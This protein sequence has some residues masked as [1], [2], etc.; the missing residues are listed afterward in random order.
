[1]EDEANH[2]YS[3]DTICHDYAPG[4]YLPMANRFDGFIICGNNGESV[5]KKCQSGLIYNA[6]T[7]TCENGNRSLLNIDVGKGI[8]GAFRTLYIRFNIM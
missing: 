2:Q 6:L 1:M 5:A 7:T 8:V 4:T 3:L